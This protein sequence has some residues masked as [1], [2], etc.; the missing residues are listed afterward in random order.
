M[1]Q[2]GSCLYQLMGCYLPV[3]MVRT[4]LRK[5]I[6][7]LRSLPT[8]EQALSGEHSPPSMLL[9]LCLQPLVFWKDLRV[10]GQVRDH[11]QEARHT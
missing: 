1:P 3:D 10:Q 11:N 8:T 7:D 4:K 5:V 2:S 9:M 6:K